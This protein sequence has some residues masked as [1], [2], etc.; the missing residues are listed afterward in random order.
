MTF[1]LGI[2]VTAV[3]FLKGQEPMPIGAILDES[4]FQRRFNPG[5]AAFVD[6]GFFLLAGGGFDVE[7]IEPLAI[8]HGD[9]QLFL[10]SGVNQH[11]FH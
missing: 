3:D 4:R 5:D 7:V 9:A 8:H 2:E 6:V 10:L 11:S 1:G